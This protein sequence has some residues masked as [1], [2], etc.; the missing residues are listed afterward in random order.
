[1]AMLLFLLFFHTLRTRKQTLLAVC[2][3]TRLLSD[4]LWRKNM[5]IFGTTRIMVVS[6]QCQNKETTTIYDNS[7]IKTN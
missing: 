1:M 2:P 7:N 3:K 6:L 4:V 5:K